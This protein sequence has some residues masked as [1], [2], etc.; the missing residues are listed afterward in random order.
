MDVGELPFVYPFREPALD[1]REHHKAVSRQLARI[2][3]I[4]HAN[5]LR[6]GVILRH[7]QGVTRPAQ[8]VSMQRNHWVIR[9]MRL[10]RNENIARHKFAR[11]R[12]INDQLALPFLFFNRLNKYWRQRAPLLWETT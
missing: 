7:A 8:P 5:V 3:I 10:V 9:R 6:L 11:L 1:W 4:M 2:I 12:L